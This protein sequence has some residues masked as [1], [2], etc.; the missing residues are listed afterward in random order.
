MIPVERTRAM[1]GKRNLDKDQQKPNRPRKAGCISMEEIRDHSISHLEQRGLK[2]SNSFRKDRGAPS[3][4]LMTD[5]ESEEE[6]DSVNPLS[7]RDRNFDEAEKLADKVFT[8]PLSEEAFRTMHAEE[9]DSD[10]PKI[11]SL[12]GARAR[13]GRTIKQIEQDMEEVMEPEHRVGV[14]QYLEEPLLDDKERKPKQGPNGKSPEKLLTTTDSILGEAARFGSSNQSESTIH[15]GLWVALQQKIR[16]LM[17]ERAKQ[18]LRSNELN[19]YLEEEPLLHLFQP[20][21]VPADVRLPDQTNSMNVGSSLPKEATSLATIRPKYPGARSNAIQL[22]AS[23]HAYAD[24]QMGMCDDWPSPPEL[25]K[26][27]HFRSNALESAPDDQQIFCK[28]ETESEVEAT[29]TSPAVENVERPSLMPQENPINNSSNSHAHWIS[30][31]RFMQCHRSSTRDFGS[32]TLTKGEFEFLLLARKMV[33]KRTNIGRSDNFFCGMCL[34]DTCAHYSRMMCRAC[35]HQYKFCSDF[36][37]YVC[38]NDELKETI[39]K[40]GSTK[41][42]VGKAYDWLK[43]LSGKKWEPVSV[44]SIAKKCGI[45]IADN[46]LRDDEEPPLE[47]PTD[48]KFGGA[49]SNGKRLAESAVLP[50][51]ATLH[52]FDCER[53]NTSIEKELPTSWFS[54]PKGDPSTAVEKAMDVAKQ[55]YR[56]QQEFLSTVQNCWVQY[57]RG[58]S[59]SSHNPDF[60]NPF[61]EDPV[62]GFSEITEN[63][64]ND[65][66]SRWFSDPDKILDGIPPGVN[67]KLRFLAVETE[68]LRLKYNGHQ[69]PDKILL[70]EGFAKIRD[71]LDEINESVKSLHLSWERAQHRIFECVPSKVMTAV[72]S[73]FY[74]TIA[75]SK[76]IYGHHLLVVPAAYLRMWHWM[77]QWLCP[78]H[79]ISHYGGKPRTRVQLRKGWVQSSALQSDCSQGYPFASGSHLSHICLVSAAKFLHDFKHFQKAFWT[80]VTVQSHGPPSSS[81][82]LPARTSS[83]CSAAAQLDTISRVL[84]LPPPASAEVAGQAGY[85]NAAE[86]PYPNEIVLSRS[87]PD[88]FGPSDAYNKD[89]ADAPYDLLHWVFSDVWKHTEGD[90]LRKARQELAHISSWYETRVSTQLFLSNSPRPVD[91]A[92]LESKLGDINPGIFLQLGMEDLVT[93][94]RAWPEGMCNSPFGRLPSTYCLPVRL[95]MIFLQPSMIRANLN[96][97]LLSR[98]SAEEMKTQFSSPLDRNA[99]L[100]SNTEITSSMFQRA[101]TNGRTDAMSDDPVIVGTALEIQSGLLPLPVVDWRREEVAKAMGVAVESTEPIDDEI[102]EDAPTPEAGVLSA[103]EKM[104]AWEQKKTLGYLRRAR[105]ILAMLNESGRIP[106]SSV[107]ALLQGDQSLVNTW[108]ELQT[109][110]DHFLGKPLAALVSADGQWG[111]LL[112]EAYFYERAQATAQEEIR[113]AVGDNSFAKVLVP[114]GESFVLGRCGREERYSLEAAGIKAMP[115]N[116]VGDI[117]CIISKDDRM[118]RVQASIVVREESGHRKFFLGVHGLASVFVDGRLYTWGRADVGTAN[119]SEA[120]LHH[121]SVIGVADKILIFLEAS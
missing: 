41:R 102:S 94:L 8:N 67:V 46:V 27:S 12:T 108:Q 50:W 114:A 55:A 43:T 115:G 53:M 16:L 90:T 105:A 96:L 6:E 81:Y 60:Q 62:P 104:P 30:L 110:A 79:I 47:Y 7:I 39:N 17:K 42:L 49:P 107:P 117:H 98:P 9:A 106:P 2:S 44:E 88:V 23:C 15:V 26:L 40:S 31:E 116:R 93:A 57:L 58:F 99:S 38:A 54:D 75:F 14:Q 45:T 118:S 25:L 66:L 78:D 1:G 121:G 51:M 85:E 112:R 5:T 33:K 3:W 61:A 91:V 87:L 80:S 22:L 69:D 19:A 86:G 18:A 73:C 89:K 64:I 11:N 103:L 95:S 24:L 52:H 82:V 111:R 92:N 20:K 35:A 101:D 29:K 100:T 63:S 109:A 119:N 59:R 84:I 77:L 113:K 21:R 32:K 71:T 120:P 13:R 28:V 97:Q 56:M 65:P 10:I 76:G 70:G 83:V 37:D 68:K 34:R 72:V 36:I 48:F 74:S 4:D